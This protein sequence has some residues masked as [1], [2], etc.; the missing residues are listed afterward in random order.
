MR[1]QLSRALAGGLRL[2]TLVGHTGS[3]GSWL[4][5]A[6]Q[7]DLILAGTVDQTT[8]ATVPFRPLPRAL[9]RLQP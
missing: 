9:A 3:T 6:P 7:L 1:F 4:W 8:A 5:H 2:P